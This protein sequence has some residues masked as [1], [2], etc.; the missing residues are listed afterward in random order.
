MD[1]YGSGGDVAAA[2]DLWAQKNMITCHHLDSYILALA[3]VSSNPKF[4]NL[5]DSV[6]DNTLFKQMPIST[7]F[8]STLH[9]MQ[10]IFYIHAII[11]YSWIKLSCYFR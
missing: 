10:M 5:S 1:E 11:G 8:F 3:T 2:V 7:P 4:M 9:K 6:I